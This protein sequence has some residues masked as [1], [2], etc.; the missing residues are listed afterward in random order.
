MAT[1]SLAIHRS[2]SPIPKTLPL[3]EY[4]RSP[5]PPIRKRLEDHDHELDNHDKIGQD[6]DNDSSFSDPV[7]IPWGLY[8]PVLFICVADAMTYSVIFPFITDMITSFDVPPDKI[9]LYS[10]LGEGVMMLVEAAGATTWA[11][12]GDKY[13]RRP[14]IIIGFSVTVMAM[15][16][17]AFS[18]SVTQVVLARAISEST[19][20]E[21]HALILTNLSGL[22]SRWCA[23]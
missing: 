9:G 21:P 22:E 15:P 8:A 16:V 7:P 17:L 13:G 5:S 23:R 18:R 6:D 19:Q 12:L 20:E 4:P 2:P 3:Y 1:N 14:C 10:G 11:R